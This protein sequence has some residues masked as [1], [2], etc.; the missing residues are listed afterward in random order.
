MTKGQ[1]FTTF[2][3]L[4]IT[5]PFFYLCA[6]PAIL[7]FGMAKGGFGG[8]ISILSVPL[9]ALAV[10]PVQAAAILLPI[11]VVMDFFALN[12]FR[13]QCSVENLKIIIPGAAMGILVGTF[14]FSYLSADMIRIIMGA[15]AVI[16]TL[17][18][19]FKRKI[20][21]G[22]KPDRLKG[23]IWSA[24][25]GFTSFGVH[26]G[27]PPISIYLLPQKM[28]KA[29]LMGTFAWFFSVV[30][31]LKLIPYTWLGLFDYT[32]I[33]TSLVLVPLAPVGVGLGYFL[34]NKVSVNTIYNLCYVFLFFAGISLLY[35]GFIGL[36]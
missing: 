25:A 23:T 1:F 32:N 31:L 15:I 34:L 14:T 28:D 21:Q 5:E 30:N 3:F 22:S 2:G 18:Y 10:P 13:G 36:S 26:A 12:S 16:F 8:G 29:I 6:I 11:L 4:M 33:V 9:L 17:D 35:K 7:I 20:I 19:W 27:G 24:I